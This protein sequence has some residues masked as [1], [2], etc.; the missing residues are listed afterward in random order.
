M[1]VA[2]L[3]LEEKLIDFENVHVCVLTKTVE[4]EKATSYFQEPSRVGWNIKN[5]TTFM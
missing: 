4:Y 1:Y 5:K 3:L 2:G